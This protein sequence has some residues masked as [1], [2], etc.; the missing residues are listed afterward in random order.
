VEDSGSELERKDWSA[1]SLMEKDA[2]EEQVE[3]EQLSLSKLRKDDWSFRPV[4]SSGCSLS[5]S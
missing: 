5:N 3:L 1:S 2:V 4:S